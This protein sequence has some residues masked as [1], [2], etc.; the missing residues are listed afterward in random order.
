M[1]PCTSPP[2]CIAINP[3][4]SRRTM[5]IAIAGSTPTRRFAMASSSDSPCMLSASIVS[6]PAF[7]AMCISFGNPDTDASSK[8][9][10][11]L[12]A[13]AFPIRKR[14]K[15]RLNRLTTV[16]AACGVA[17]SMTAQLAPLVL[18]W[19]CRG[20]REPTESLA[21]GPS[22]FCVLLVSFIALVVR[23][24]GVLLRR[25]SHGQFEAQRTNRVDP[26]SA[27]DC[28]TNGSFS[29]RLST[30]VMDRKG[31]ATQ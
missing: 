17:G 18:R 21:V 15:R 2:A 4:A 5:S 27:Q 25:Y 28:N 16:V 1:S 7:M 30:N 31:M 24:G 3:S 22:V 26:P 8:R 6:C 13:V 12:R 10:K 14:V 9:V 23:V 20:T 19:M 29:T 11:R